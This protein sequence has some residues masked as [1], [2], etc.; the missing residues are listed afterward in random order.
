MSHRQPQ[1]TCTTQ[2]VAH[3]CGK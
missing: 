1:L 3:L 2:F